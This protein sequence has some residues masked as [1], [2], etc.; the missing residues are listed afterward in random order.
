MKK[1]QCISKRLP[2]LSEKVSSPA[3]RRGKLTPFTLIELLVVIA[4]IAIL[5]AML[6]P[7]LQQARNRAHATSCLNNLKT[8]GTAIG[9]YI[10]E[11]QGCIIRVDKFGRR[12]DGMKNEYGFLSPYLDIQVVRLGT[13]SITSTGT[14]RH[15]LACPS[16]EIG[17]ARANYATLGLSEYIGINDWRK[18]L[19]LTFFRRP[20]Q[21]LCAGDSYGNQTTAY[22]TASFGNSLTMG[23]TSE[24]NKYPE[25]RHGG[26]SNLLYADLHV[27]TGFSTTWFDSRPYRY[28]WVPS[29]AQ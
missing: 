6:L 2:V 23:Q 1:T 19:K 26:K 5:A 18:S 28:F 20:G 8:V 13:V 14:Y 10:D 24:K 4:I 29:D 9:M 15:K 11:N 12:W 3:D 21:T 27:G 16:A 17:T 22:V 25:P 7:A